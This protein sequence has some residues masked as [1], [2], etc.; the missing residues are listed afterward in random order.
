MKD[1]IPWVVVYATEQK[2][3]R[4]WTT[5]DPIEDYEKNPD[6][7]EHFGPYVKLVSWD[8]VGE[9]LKDGLPL[10]K[11]ADP[12]KLSREEK[13]ALDFVMSG[14]EDPAWTA[15]HDAIVKSD[16]NYKRRLE[17]AQKQDQRRID[18]KAK[19]L[20]AKQDAKLQKLMPDLHGMVTRAEH[21]EVLNHNAALE[22]ELEDVKKEKDSTITRDQLR[23][24]ETTCNF[25][26]EMRSHYFQQLADK[27]RE[28]ADKGETLKKLTEL[29]PVVARQIFSWEELQN[30]DAP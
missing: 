8:T 29:I 4:H 12:A 17:K 26:N 5:A 19:L 28:R 11:T 25:W 22:Q 13:Q 3:T 15:K 30:V 24:L 20:K 21:D 7:K 27:N 18:K 9:C 16:K 23:Q 14:L 10:S 6:T 2:Y 1:Q